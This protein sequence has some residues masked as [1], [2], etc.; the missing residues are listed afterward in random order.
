M[1]KEPKKDENE[2]QKNI[3]ETKKGRKK[4]ERKNQREVKDLGGKKEKREREKEKKKSRDTV[5]TCTCNV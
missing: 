5:T 1:R 4:E 2:R 3:L